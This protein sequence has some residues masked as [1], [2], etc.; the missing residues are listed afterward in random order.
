MS[1]RRLVLS[2]LGHGLHE[3]DVLGEARRREI[4]PAQLVAVL[5]EE[6][7]GSLEDPGGAVREV[8]AAAVDQC[9]DQRAGLLGE[10]E[11]QHEAAPEEGVRQRALLVRRDHHERRARSVQR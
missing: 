3:V 7:G 10:R 2:L 9:L 5:G 4:L 1:V 11:V 6:L 8:R